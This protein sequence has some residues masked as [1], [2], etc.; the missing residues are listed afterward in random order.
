MR[1]A[2]AD[3]H[4]LIRDGVRS[5]LAT[6]GDIEVV[7]EASDGLQV[8]E[9]LSKCVPDLLL[10][11]V[12]MPGLNGLEVTRQIIKKRPGLRIIILS[13]YANEGFV[14]QALKFGAMGYVL[15]NAGSSELKKAIRSV[16]AGKRYLSPPLSD[17][18]IE[19]YV[20]KVR[21]TGMDEMQA[22][23]DRERTI[24]QMAAEGLSSNQIA[25]RLFIS[26]RTVETHRANVMRKLHLQSHTDLIR[27]ALRHGIISLD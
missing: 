27:F 7:G 22:L 26:P 4:K 23:T 13:M 25:E 2:I 17:L 14:L 6:E 5:L 11:D 8:E 10:L 21:S 3:D 12:M 24:L 19:A 18:A 9:M 16:T 20:E 15:K 1:I